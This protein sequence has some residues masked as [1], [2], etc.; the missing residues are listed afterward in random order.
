MSG[1]VAER[2]ITQQKKVS[3]SVR[4]CAALLEIPKFLFYLIF[5]KAGIGS[6]H[7]KNEVHMDSILY[8]YFKV[9][10][11]HFAY[12]SIN[13]TSAATNASAET[14]ERFLTLV[15]SYNNCTHYGFDMI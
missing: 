5:F 11:E 2:G 3:G 6:F 9:K 14:S 13:I 7:I 4:N 15:C 1:A 12:G 8:I 10:L